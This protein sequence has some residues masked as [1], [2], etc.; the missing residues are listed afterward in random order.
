MSIKF[1][2]ITTY[3]DPLAQCHWARLPLLDLDQSHL[4]EDLDFHLAVLMVLCTYCQCKYTL[5]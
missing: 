4:L 1:F 5:W 3:I 2:Q